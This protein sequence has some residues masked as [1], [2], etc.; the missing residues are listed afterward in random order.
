MSKRFLSDRLKH[1]CSKQRVLSRYS[2][3]LLPWHSSICMCVNGSTACWVHSLWGTVRNL[4]AQCRNIHTRSLW[5][6]TSSLGNTF[7][8]VTCIV[9]QNNCAALDRHKRLQKKIML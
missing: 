4:I 9:V 8:S 2:G 3:I 5:K 6:F 1:V 7:Y